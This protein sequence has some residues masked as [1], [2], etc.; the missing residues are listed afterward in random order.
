MGIILG[1]LGDLGVECVELQEIA[2]PWSQF[3]FEI[4]Q[5]EDLVELLWGIVWNEQDRDIQWL[6]AAVDK[7]VSFGEVKNQQRL[8]QI[9]EKMEKLNVAPQLHV[10]LESLMKED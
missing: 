10:K 7:L 3:Q 4:I 9:M 5:C 1:A 8:Q 2:M 6:E